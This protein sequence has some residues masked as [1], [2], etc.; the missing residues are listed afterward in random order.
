MAG[1]VFDRMTINFT[2]QKELELAAK[3][4]EL[5]G[6]RNVNRVLKELVKRYVQEQ[7]GVGKK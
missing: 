1:G 4:R 6:Y 2:N 7:E 3:F 5:T